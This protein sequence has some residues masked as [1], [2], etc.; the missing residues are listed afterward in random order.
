MKNKERHKD[1]K[2]MASNFEISIHRNS[3]NLHVKMVGDFDGNSV[4]ELLD[5]LKS[6]EERLVYAD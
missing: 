2:I 6:R 4:H 3:E 1:E 5:I